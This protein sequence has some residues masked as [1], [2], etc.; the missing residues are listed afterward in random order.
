MREALK[1]RADGQR[2]AI[3]KFYEKIAPIDFSGDILDVHANRL[4]MLRVPHCG[5]TDLGT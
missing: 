3:K 1:Q 4:H 5:W 2:D